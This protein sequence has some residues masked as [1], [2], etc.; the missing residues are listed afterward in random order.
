MF[1]MCRYNWIA[2]KR[3]DYAFECLDIGMANLAKT[4]PM[5]DRM[6]PFRKMLWHFWVWDFN[7][8]L[9]PEK[10]LE[11]ISCLQR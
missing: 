10:P 3:I 6:W 5:I 9:E 2:S 1:V 11:H 7:K 8:M 4:Q